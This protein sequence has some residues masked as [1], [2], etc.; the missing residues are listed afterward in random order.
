MKLNDLNIRH[1]AALP[2]QSISLDVLREKYAK[3]DEKTIG[4]VRKRIARA[5]S[6]VEPPDQREGWEQAFVAAQEAGFIPGGRICSA[7]GTDLKATLINCF[8]QPIGDSISA[9]E[10]TPVG[11]YDALQ[12][13]A[14]TMRRGGGVGYDFSPIRPAGAWVKG[15]QSS[16]SG[17]LSYMRV[18]D[19]SC[20]RSSPPAR[21]AA[22][23]W[24][25]CAATI[26]T[27]ANS[28]R[29]G[30]RRFQELQPLGGVHAGVHGGGR[31]RSRVAARARGASRR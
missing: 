2:P 12:Q 1:A 29:E 23:R 27:C 17:P 5:L 25:S 24:A 28:S 6:Q 21:A 8:V 3:G 31:R 15:T 20:R 9:D 7:A 4:D 19:E 18:F 30:R 11:I 14:E 26:R 10:T 13:A 22:R 16:A